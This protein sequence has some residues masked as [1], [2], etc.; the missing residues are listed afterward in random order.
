M[1]L[2]NHERLIIAFVIIMM[3]ILPVFIS[4]TPF[5]INNQCVYIFPDSIKIN[6]I[7]AFSALIVGILAFIGTIYNTNKTSLIMRVSAIPEKSANLLMDLEFI[8]NEYEIYKQSGKKDKL[9]LLTRILLY[10]K[11]HQQAFKLLTPHFYKEFTKLISN[12]EIIMENGD[13]NFN[14]SKY[15][16]MAIL[17]HIT[18]IAVYGVETDFS[19]IKPDLIVDK[20]DVKELGEIND[21]YLS[22]IKFNEEKLSDYIDNINGVETRKLTNEKFSKLLNKIKKLLKDLNRELEEAS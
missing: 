22:D 19:F 12:Q 16:I 15:I 2:K 7:E 21:N 4:I 14:N 13:P 5:E 10:W 3:I 9:I 1:Y 18:N 20:K 11:E 17:T 6:S 8:F